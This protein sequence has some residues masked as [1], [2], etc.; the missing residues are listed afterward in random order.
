LLSFNHNKQRLTAT[1]SKR[2]RQNL[3]RPKMMP[4]RKWADADKRRKLRDKTGNRLSF[5]WLN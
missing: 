3:K 2:W 5:V 4:L 1:G